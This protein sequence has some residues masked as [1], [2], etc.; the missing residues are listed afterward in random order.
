MHVRAVLTSNIGF[1]IYTFKEMMEKHHDE[2]FY[3][4]NKK[5]YKK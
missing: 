3:G 2:D 5:L 1:E 4:I